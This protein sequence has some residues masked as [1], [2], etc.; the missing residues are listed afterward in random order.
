MK[1]RLLFTCILSFILLFLVYGSA[2]GQIQDM[3]A[4]HWAYSSVKYLIDRGVLSL[5][6]DNTFRGQNLITRY[7][8]AVLLSRMLDYIEQDAPD[9]TEGETMLLRDIST[10]FRRDLVQLAE[11]ARN[12]ESELMAMEDWR[13]ILSDEMNV[14]IRD[15]NTLEKTIEETISEMQRDVEAFQG[16]LIETEMAF[17]QKVEDLYTSISQSEE[18]IRSMEQMIRDN[19]EQR[20]RDFESRMARI[21]EEPHHETLALAERSLRQA[22]EALED[23]RRLHESLVS[24]K[25]EL[26]QLKVYSI[27]R[28]ENLENLVK[29]EERVTEDQILELEERFSTLYTLFSQLETEMVAEGR[30][31]RIELALD[32]INKD[33]NFFINRLHEFKEENDELKESYAA[34]STL[35]KALEE[36]NRELSTHYNELSR[37]FELFERK[38]NE[39]HLYTRANNTEIQSL[40]QDYERIVQE[41]QDLFAITEDLYS[42]NERLFQLSEILF[43]ES[44]A[45]KEEKDLL[46]TEKGQLIE[47]SDRLIRETGDLY[48]ITDLLFVETDN[49]KDRTSLLRFLLDE[50][51]SRIDGLQEEVRHHLNHIQELNQENLQLK[52][53]LSSL[54]SSMDASLLVVQEEMGMLLSEIEGLQRET[55]FLERESRSLREDL[56]EERGERIEQ[57]EEVYTITYELG[58]SAQGLREDTDLLKEETQGLKSATD[59]L[60]ILVDSESERLT[61]IKEETDTKLAKLEEEAQELHA[62]KDILLERLGLLEEREKELTEEKMALRANI[63]SLEESLQQY[64]EKQALTEEEIEKMRSSNMYFRAIMGLGMVL[65]SILAFGAN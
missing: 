22:E 62:E 50:E 61:K 26:D 40:K 12:L 17:H 65:I 8:F 35:Q 25:N 46:F 34:L 10:E 39:L 19:L 56:I 53:Q 54:K 64:E 2:L 23:N 48:E 15:V 43:E 7:Q 20:L 3:E 58:E 45:L 63:T 55:S 47:E 5:Y 21:E 31:G 28:I 38:H 29:D 30:I 1:S 51:T 37:S 24:L 14:V 13:V 60:Q 57:L 41:N 27:N 9:L 59:G 6:E 4:D 16:N 52:E 44:A 49:L 42:Q 18:Q 33:I 11:K 32:D 36:K